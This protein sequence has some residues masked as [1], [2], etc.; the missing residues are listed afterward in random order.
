MTARFERG[1]HHLSASSVSSL[2]DG[3]SHADVS[4]DSKP[5][6]V[7]LAKQWEIILEL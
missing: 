7:D 4:R 3:S 2:G 1:L 5:E 6:N